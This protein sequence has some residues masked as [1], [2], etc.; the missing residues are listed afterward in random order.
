MLITVAI[1]TWNRAKLLKQCL[2]QMTKLVIPPD[3]EWELLVVNNNCTD[4]TDQVI[5]S[6]SNRLPIRRLFEPKQGLSHTRNLAASEAK[7]DYILWT[8]DDVLVDSNW[9]VVYEN[10][11]QRWP[12][13]AYFGGFIEPWYEKQPPKWITSDLQFFSGLILNRDF[14]HVERPF[15]KTEVPYGAN[16]A[17]QKWIFNKWKFNSRL[18]RNANDHILSEEVELL[19]NLK[20]YGLK[21]VWVPAAKVEHWIPVHRLTKKYTWNYFHGLGRTVIRI[22]GIPD[23]KLLL[24]APRWLYRKYLE[25][26]VKYYLQLFSGR[27]DWTKTFVAAAIVAG[28][29]CESRSHR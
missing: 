24:G 19:N 4:D 20:A 15:L 3:V 13:A 11:F 18:G 10:A 14:G 29:I 9:L 26:L 21:G 22:E 2:E 7:G 5:A 12:K 28:K 6:F 8:D 27:R 17:F 23:G 16:M 1:C 25:L